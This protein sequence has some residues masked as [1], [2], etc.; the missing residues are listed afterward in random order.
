MMLSLYSSPS[1]LKRDVAS[2]GVGV[3]IAVGTTELP[4]TL[5]RDRNDGVE[6]DTTRSG[7]LHVERRSVF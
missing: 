5:Q 7:S 3:C 4:T 1:L 2:G 6:K